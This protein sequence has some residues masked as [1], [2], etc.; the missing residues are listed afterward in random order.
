M[1]SI[2]AAK[3]LVLSLV[4]GKNTPQDGIRAGARGAE[5]VRLASNKAVQPSEFDK[6]AAPSPARPSRNPA[7]RRRLAGFGA[8]LQPPSNVPLDAIAEALAENML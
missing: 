7:G 5:L 8:A 2:A 1:A 6:P 4:N 3:D